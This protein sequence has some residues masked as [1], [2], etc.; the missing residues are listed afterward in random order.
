THTAVMA[1][2]TNEAEANWNNPQR[3]QNVRDRIDDETADY[4]LKHG[5]SSEV[6]RYQLGEN[7]DK[8]WSAVIKRQALSGDFTGAMKTYR[9]QV[10]AGRI[11]GSAQGDLEKFFKPIQD[12]Q[13]AQ[14]A[15]GK[16]T[17]GAMAQQIAGEAQ[18]Q[19]VDPGTALTIWSAEGGV[20]NPATK[21]PASSATGIFQHLDSTWKAQGGTDQDRLD[22]GRQVQLGVALVKQNTDALAKDLGRQPQPWEVYLAHQQGIG[23]ATA[24]IHA[25]PNT[26]AGNVVGNP[27]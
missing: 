17:G 18:R 24:L 2:L 27:K 6:F 10:S 26:N 8:L 22:T 7:N 1:D 14:N 19:G 12:L 15:Y 20:S 3:L 21:N 23:G 13:S 16:V 9:D 11:S 4:G 25:D 5:W